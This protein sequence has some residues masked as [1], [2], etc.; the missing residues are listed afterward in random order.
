S[1][2]KTRGFVLQT[3][4]RVRTLPGGARVPVVHVYGRLEQGGSFLIRD[5]RQRPHFYI[6]AT[7]AQRAISL[8]TPTPQPTDQ[9]TFAGEA[10]CRIET[11]EPGEVPAIRDRLH[12]AGIDTY[13]ADVR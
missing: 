2:M 8:R 5:D 6:R 1:A 10:V 7:D 13:E 4:Y 12:A 9:R 3:S 11:V